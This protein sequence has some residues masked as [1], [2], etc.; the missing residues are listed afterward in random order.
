MD[1]ENMAIS[2]VSKV[3]SK[4]D[5]L[6]P[7]INSNDT[8]PTWD[9][10]VYAYKHPG[11]N[12]SKDDMLGRV[13]VQVK[14]HQANLPYPETI[15]FSAD[16]SDLN[17]YMGESGCIYLVVYC[18]DD[19]ENEQI[20]YKVLLPYDL[21]NILKDCTN[22]ATKTI[23]LRPLPTGKND[24]SNIFLNFVRDRKKQYAS[25]QGN[26]FSLDDIA[27]DGQ[28]PELSF[29]YTTVSVEDREPT[30]YMLKYGLYVY[31]KAGYGLEFAVDHLENIQMV[32][33]KIQ[34]SITIGEKKYYDNYLVSRK[35]GGD[36]EVKIGKG[37][38][39]TIDSNGK[40]VKID[41]SL[42][43][44]LQERIKDLTSVI[45]A[46]DA[47]GFY[48]NGVEIPIRNASTQDYIDFDI[49]AKKEH[50]Q[51][52]TIAKKTLDMLHV[53]NDLDMD[54]MDEQDYRN[55]NL[56]ISSVYYG[57]WV[58]MS[59]TGK[60]VG[61]FHIANLQII[62][63]VKKDPERGLFKIT[64]FFLPTLTVRMALEGKPENGV[65]CPSFVTIL[66]QSLNTFLYIQK[67]E[68]ALNL[69]V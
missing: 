66:S 28:I 2:A 6:T 3:I 10:F 41:L 42:K 45:D 68:A 14:G 36:T 17:N 13:P 21:H 11:N 18:D 48:I 54:A 44:T 30:T 16:I 62:V 46:F 53:Q 39:V 9:G 64:D 51:E 15:S 1:L 57:K 7:A 40:S 50:L 63:C 24:V 29:G 22:K 37:L 59:D 47:G 4:T 12:H 19:G 60:V 23:H 69:M 31:A 52:L 20:Y 33:T 61:Y 35:V 58:P 56:L 26:V 25:V 65:D 8:Q 32:T 38:S 49:S 55:L 43:G 67:K 27:K 34:R 5:Y